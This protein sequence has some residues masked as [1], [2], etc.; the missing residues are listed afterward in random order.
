[1]PYRRPL[2][3]QSI[4]AKLDQL[5][6]VMTRQVEAT[7][8][9]HL[10]MTQR[11]VVEAGELHTLLHAIHDA[12]DSAWWTA[13]QIRERSRQHDGAG[14]MLNEELLALGCAPAKDGSEKPLSALLG[15][16]A[17]RQFGRFRLERSPKKQGNTWQWRVLGV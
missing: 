10:A 11:G 13:R 12:F 1:M 7:A 3:L 9:L 2:D 4:D 15:V 16:H 14:L 6:A 5:L 17:G 8:R